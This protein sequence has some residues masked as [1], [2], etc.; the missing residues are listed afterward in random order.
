MYVLYCNSEEIPD[1]CITNPTDMKPDSTDCSRYFNCSA[2][3]SNKSVQCAYPDLFS[4]SKLK[5]VEFTAATC[6]MRYEPMAPCKYY[7]FTKSYKIKI[8]A[9]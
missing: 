3:S 5:C 6:G 1:F 9:H 4:E 2:V 7:I 8:I